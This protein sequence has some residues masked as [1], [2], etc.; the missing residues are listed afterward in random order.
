MKCLKNVKKRNAEGEIDNEIEIND[1][2][3]DVFQIIIHYIKKK[4]L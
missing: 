3:F 2:A 1:I 4:V